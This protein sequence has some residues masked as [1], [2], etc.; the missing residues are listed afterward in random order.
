M[1]KYNQ[2]YRYRSYGELLANVQVGSLPLSLGANVHYGDDSY[3]QSDLGLVSGLDRRYGVD[4]NWTVNEKISAY[5]TLGRE[6]IDSKTKGSSNFA[7]RQLDRRRAGRLRDLR[8][9]GQ[10]AADRPHQ[11]QLR[12]HLRGGRLAHAA[13]TGAGGGAFP[14]VKSELSSMQAGVTY[15]LNARAD[16][17]LNVV[18][19]DAVDQRLGLLVGSRPR[20]RRCSAWA[21]IPTTTTSTT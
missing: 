3:L 2:A 19:R 7:T 16:L 21:S 8:R 5:A 9:R 1:R 20:C 13:V 10:R 15:G 14:T 6:K 4:L 17:A 18:V 11:R 12:L